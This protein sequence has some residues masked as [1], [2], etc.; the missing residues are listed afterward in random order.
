M[1]VRQEAQKTGWVSYQGMVE[2]A[3]MAT[4]CQVEMQAKSCLTSNF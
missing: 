1:G 4:G 3:A 2:K